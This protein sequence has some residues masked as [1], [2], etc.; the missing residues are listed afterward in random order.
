MY[1]RVYR[2]QGPAT[3]TRVLHLRA[4]VVVFRCIRLTR[5]CER[6]TVFVLC[7]SDCKDDVNES[8]RSSPGH[9][10]RDKTPRSRGDETFHDFLSKASVSE[11]SL[12]SIAPVPTHGKNS[13]CRPCTIILLRY[14]I[15]SN[16]HKFQTLFSDG[17]LSK[18][19]ARE[20]F[21]QF[22]NTMREQYE[23]ALTD[24][25]RVASIREEM[26]TA[27]EEKTGAKNQTNNTSGCKLSDLLSL[28]DAVPEKQDHPDAMRGNHD[29]VAMTMTREKFRRAI[30]TCFVHKPQLSVMVSRKHFLSVAKIKT[31]IVHEVSNYKTAKDW[32]QCGPRAFDMLFVCSPSRRSSSIASP[33]VWRPQTSQTTHRRHRRK[34]LSLGQP[35]EKQRRPTSKPNRPLRRPNISK[36]I[37]DVI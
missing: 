4:S 33:S 20:C 11:E 24:S 16:H 25:T 32:Q 28:V 5:S 31:L 7:E 14:F 29:S 22:V 1:P 36:Y 34:P 19:T 17:H 37:N 12:T 21:S 6:V 30:K 27:V 2:S 18:E 8:S 15:H 23:P 26:G 9:P 3:R 13:R 35:V 10:N